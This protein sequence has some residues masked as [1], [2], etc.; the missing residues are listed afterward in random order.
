M[1]RWFTDG[2]ADT[3]VVTAVAGLEALTG[4]VPWAEGE[5]FLVSATN[6]VVAYC[7]LSGAATPEL[8]A[9]YDEAFPG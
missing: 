8:E 4:S 2:E 9:M 5:R 7:G 1:D 6:G 3:V